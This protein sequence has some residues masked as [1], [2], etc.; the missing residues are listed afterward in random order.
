M[1]K[2]DQMKAAIAEQK[3]KKLVTNVGLK[4]TNAGA[5]VKV[6]P[7]TNVMATATTVPSNKAKTPMRTCCPTLRGQGEHMSE[8]ASRNPQPKK[9]RKRRPSTPFG[10]DL[11]DGNKG[12]WPEQTIVTS[13]WVGGEWLVEARVPGQ[14]SISRKGSGIHKT[15][16]ML[17]LDWLESQLAK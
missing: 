6:V 5:T 10:F 11:H 13:A 2:L 14:T 15:I 12:R 16:S 17:F 9:E 4:V 8:C 7:V 3:A 1:G